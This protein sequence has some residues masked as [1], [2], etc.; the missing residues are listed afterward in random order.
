M[1]N[2]IKPNI[3]ITGTF[4]VH[5]AIKFQVSLFISHQAAIASARDEDADDPEIADFKGLQ[6]RR[7][8]LHRTAEVLEVHDVVVQKLITKARDDLVRFSQDCCCSS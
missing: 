5:F 2:E 8:N 1:E 4:F 7:D 3:H 6:H